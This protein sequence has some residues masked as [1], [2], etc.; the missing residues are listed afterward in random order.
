MLIVI[1]IIVSRRA[2][3]SVFSCGREKTH[4]KKLRFYL[5]EIGMAVHNIAPTRKNFPQF[6][7]DGQ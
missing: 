6:G 5:H 4:A 2:L 1:A 3:F 7:G